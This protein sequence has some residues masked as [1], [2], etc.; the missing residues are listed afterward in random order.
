MKKNTGLFLLLVLL[1][2][3]NANA[4]SSF[5]VSPSGSDM[6]NGSLVS[7]FL[8]LEKAQTA[9]RGS[10]IKTTCLRS[11]TYTR[12]YTFILTSQDNGTTWKT[13]PGDALNSAVID[14][15][16]IQDVIH[17][18]GG[19]N[20]TI[21]G[22]TVKNFTSRGIG[23]HGGGAWNAA[24]PYGN[25]AYGIAAGNIITNNIVQDG[26]IPDKGW[27]RAGIYAMG[28]VPN[29]TIAH[30]LIQNTTGYGIGVWSCPVA[31]HNISNLDISS[32]VLLNV[33]RGGTGYD[34]GAIYVLDKP[35]GTK[36]TSTNIKITN[37]FIRDYGDASAAASW[38]V[39]LDNMCSN[40]TVSGNIIAGEGTST[41]HI[42]GGKNV[43]I[44]GNILDMGSTGKDVLKYGKFLSNPASPALTDNAF[45]GNVILSSTTSNSAAFWRGSLATEDPQI[46]N[47]F[48]YN[49]AGPSIWRGTY[50]VVDASPVYGWPS[51]S[52][53]TY[54]IAANS[55][56]YSS[57][58]NFPQLARGW[59]PAGYT[60]PNTGSAPS[61]VNAAGAAPTSP[62]ALAAIVS[63][64]RV[65]LLWSPF[66]NATGYKVKRSATSGG[67]YTDVFPAELTCSDIDY[68][69]ID[70]GLTNGTTYYYV[71]SAITPGESPNSAQVSATPMS[72]LPLQLKATANDSLSG[73]TNRANSIGSC[74]NGDW[75]RF[76]DV[77]M[78]SGF[79]TFRANCAVPAQY[80][81]KSVE[82]RLDSPT[83]TLTGTL[84]I[85]STGSFDVYE[86]QSTTLSNATG[87]HDVY[88]KFVGGS[89]V[90]NFRWFEFE[91]EFGDAN[92]TRVVNVK[93]SSSNKTTIY[94]NPLGCQALSVSF[95]GFETTEKVSLS[96]V[97]ISGR[98]IYDQL[99][100]PTGIHKINRN[101]LSK[102]I[103][104]VN[105]KTQSLFNEVSK[106]I[107]N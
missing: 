62:I 32:N 107:V 45:Y 91:F 96:V 94:P 1:M 59:G 92:T 8:T 75:V 77:Y 3:I 41:V 36:I 101:R 90:G 102:G 22:L 74:D 61:C 14:G 95:D 64:A 18:L 12:T 97:D 16:G 83:G 66:A 80:A 25:V 52:G 46:K 55:P 93:L 57:P 56:I 86:T 10:S 98:I 31:G 11:G 87:K 6:N 38:A 70:N 85:A 106:L 21:D 47:N 65:S 5:Y 68:S 50:N 15:A 103:C 54:S 19:N 43:T 34:G 67:P 39:Y 71:V 27:D 20:I 23:I 35:D 28:D 82:I 105:V 73:V 4:Q 13:Y 81:G 24:A 48:Y 44:T 49:Y 84:V 29:T 42:H 58:V 51:I 2:Q 79:T 72:N 60:I 53:W 40:V 99:V 9:M 33:F 7:P 63:N 17:I 26:V 30:N 76:K 88:I 100:Q 78:G 89:G 69:Y 37:N 104:F